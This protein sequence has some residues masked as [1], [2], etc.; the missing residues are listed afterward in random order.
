MIPEYKLFH[1][2]VL[3]DIVDRYDGV[4][5]IGERVDAGRLL[6][7]VLNEKVGIQ[8]KYSTAR[9]RPW[10]FSFPSAH[11]EQIHD[12]LNEFPVSFVVLVCRTDGFACVPAVDA[13]RVLARDTCGASWLRVDRRKREMFRVFGPQGELEARL[14]TTSE[15]VVDALRLGTVSNSRTRRDAE[16]VD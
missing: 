7:Y 9:L 8:V 10:F 6:N 14:Q 13:L 15:P 4:V 5:G 16:P 2:A 3:A 12:L 11:I 1:G